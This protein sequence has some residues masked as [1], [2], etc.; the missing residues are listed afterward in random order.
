VSSF[1]SRGKLGALKLLQSNVKFQKAFAQL[2]QDWS[3]TT[4]LFNCL[5]EFT[6]RMY[7]PQ[8]DICDVNEMRYQLFR[9]KNGNIDSGQL[10]P[11]KDSLHMHSIRANYQ[12]AIWHRSL[13]ANP[14]VPSPVECHGRE[15]D[16][17]QQL[18][19]NWMTGAPAPDAILDFL[20]CKSKRSCVLPACDCMANGLKCSEACILQTCDNMK[21]D[22]QEQELQIDDDNSD[23]DDN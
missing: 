17:D 21:E 8:T 10:P 7:A 2:G 14:D 13:Q 19:I 9:L 6:C 3:M 20:F 22:E 12:A 5:E 11:C 23:S 15:L 4:E 16:D 18:K 1:S